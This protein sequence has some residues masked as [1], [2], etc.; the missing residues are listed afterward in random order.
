[1][2]SVGLD[3]GV[4]TGI[5]V[6]SVREG[7]PGVYGINT[8]SFVYSGKEKGIKRAI[9]IA[10]TI[11]KSIQFVEP[12]DVVVVEDYALH[13]T[14]IS[15]TTE[16][17]TAVRIQLYRLWK[18]GRILEMWKIPPTSLKKFVC[19]TGKASKDMIMMNVLKRFDY[20]A[21]SNDEAD[22]VG[23]A[24]MGLCK[25]GLDLNMP[26]ASLETLTKLTKI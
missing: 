2:I 5:A 8:C 21:P 11:F 4:T 20:E 17:G 22:A 16:I 10:S 1:M 24:A 18:K 13:G 7:Y 25:A 15:T 23:L 3:V 9:N 26:K 6:M 19:G 12:V 14:M